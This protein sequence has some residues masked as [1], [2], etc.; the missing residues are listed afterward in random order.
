MTNSPI[1]SEIA[2]RRTR[3]W[4]GE[5]DAFDGRVERPDLK[6]TVVPARVK[7]LTSTTEMAIGSV[8]SSDTRA[9]RAEDA[10]APGE[11]AA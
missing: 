1:D 8:S 10:G 2:N 7:T 3:V 6:R 11:H 5:V 4:R 9:R